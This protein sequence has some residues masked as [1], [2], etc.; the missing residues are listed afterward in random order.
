MGAE[1]AWGL[2]MQT[3]S[4]LDWNNKCMHGYGLNFCY[5]S[6]FVLNTVGSHAGMAGHFAAGQVKYNNYSCLQKPEDLIMR[7]CTIQ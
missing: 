4:K 7:H 3:L 5:I 1:H 6:A 2:N